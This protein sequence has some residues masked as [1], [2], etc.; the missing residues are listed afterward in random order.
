MDI[1][2]RHAR[3]QAGQR[4]YPCRHSFRWSRR[5]DECRRRTPRTEVQGRGGRK[6]QLRKTKLQLEVKLGK[7]FSHERLSTNAHK[8]TDTLDHCFSIT[9]QNK[10]LQS[11][12]ARMACEVHLWWLKYRLAVP[13]VWLRSNCPPS[14]EMSAGY[15]SHAAR[16]L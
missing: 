12:T 13:L 5:S 6:A 14:G 7:S 1:Q 15:L 2:T 9:S 4:G 8:K 10:C 11:C 3:W 16:C